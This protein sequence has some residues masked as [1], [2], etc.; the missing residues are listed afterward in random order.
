[1]FRQ[2]LDAITNE[3]LKP[4]WDAIPDPDDFFADK[5]PVADL[6]V[7]SLPPKLRRAEARARE[8]YHRLVKL[9]LWLAGLHVSVSE[10]ATC[11][12]RWVR[13]KEGYALGAI[14]GLLLF[15]RG[16]LIATKAILH[17]ALS[18][19]FSARRVAGGRISL[20]LPLFG[21]AW[22][23]ALL[24]VGDAVY[25]L[26]KIFVRVWTY[27][28]GNVTL[29]PLVEVL[30]TEL[31]QR[32]HFTDLILPWLNTYVLH[33]Y[34]PWVSSIASWAGGVAL[35]VVVLTVILSELDLQL[36]GSSPGRPSLSVRFLLSKPEAI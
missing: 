30:R 35:A 26:L 29:H 17:L 8:H 25:W 27:A 12:V 6:S 2:Y 1:M 20:P 9:G 22:G 7:Q 21:W 23:I 16:L 11:L 28:A 10:V 34:W 4:I 33:D 3:P 36:P 32:V 18:P 14:Q 19:R 24:L 13:F 15:G 31:D 5:P